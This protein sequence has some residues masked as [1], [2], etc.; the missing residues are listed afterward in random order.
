[1]TDSKSISV[2]DF[3]MRASQYIGLGVPLILTVY[4]RPVARVVPLKYSVENVP[5]VNDVS[6][7]KTGGVGDTPINT[8]IHTP[9]DTLHKSEEYNIN[10]IRD[11]E[12]RS[13]ILPV[14]NIIGIDSKDI[15]S[16]ITYCQELFEAGKKQKCFRV[17]YED[18][19]GVVL[20]T[21]WLCTVC[22]KT[23]DDKVRRYGGKLRY[24]I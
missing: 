18:I 4:N 5:I 6:T 12:K 16:S 2:R 7:V 3:Q 21:K 9:M 22:L 11:M 23:I 13:N 15:V 20:W 24:D 17:S 1:M 10:N 8:P 14:I 19:N